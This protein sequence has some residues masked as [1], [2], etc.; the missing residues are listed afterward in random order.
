MFFVGWVFSTCC[1]IID[2]ILLYRSYMEMLYLMIC[3]FGLS[4]GW[5]T[6]LVF[7]LNLTFFLFAYLIRDAPYWVVM[8]LYVILQPIWNLNTLFSWYPFSVTWSHIIAFLGQS[9]VVHCQITF[10]FSL[11]NQNQIAQRRSTLLILLLAF[12]H[13]SI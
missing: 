13:F 4:K 12:I 6:L 11:H 10:C 5:Y 8:L 2:L 7:K 3:R 9:F 1:T